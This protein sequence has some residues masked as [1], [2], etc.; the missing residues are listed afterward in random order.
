MS[1]RI[2]PIV[3]VAALVGCP[4]WCGSGP[5]SGGGICCTAQQSLAATCSAHTAEACCC[6]RGG[7]TLRD[8]GHADYPD[9]NPGS[10]TPNGATPN[11]NCPIRSDG[12]PC[13]GVCSGA[14]VAKPTELD[15]DPILVPLPLSLT[16]EFDRCCLAWLD[17]RQDAFNPVSPPAANYGRFLCTLHASWLC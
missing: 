12:L 10:A 15:E 2:V 13:Q 8:I 14:V 7:Q 9:A 3:L 17:C 5:C 1:D 4:L 6:D 11:G 16:D